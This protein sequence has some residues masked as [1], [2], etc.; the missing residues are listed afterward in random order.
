MQ[1]RPETAISRPP[2]PRKLRI[3]RMAKQAV[4]VKY[5]DDQTDA[6]T[7]LEEGLR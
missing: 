1:R 2:R 5:R 3:E 6:R 7:A 4:I